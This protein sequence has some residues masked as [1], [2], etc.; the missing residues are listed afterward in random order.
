VKSTACKRGY[1]TGE[2]PKGEKGEGTSRGGKGSSGT[3][4]GKIGGIPCVEEWGRMG[5]S[6]GVV[7]NKAP[8]EDL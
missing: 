8:P 1:W 5:N 7:K 4:K 6:V 3:L 2:S